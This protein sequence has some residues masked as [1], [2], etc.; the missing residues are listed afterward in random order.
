MFGRG[1][2]EGPPMSGSYVSA[3]RSPPAFLTASAATT[4]SY[5]RVLFNPLIFRSCV[6][7]A[8]PRSGFDAHQVACNRET[9]LRRALWHTA[10]NQQVEQ[11][12]CAFTFAGLPL[13]TAGGFRCRRPAVGCCVRRLHPS[14]LHLSPPPPRDATAPPMGRG[15]G[16]R[17][18]VGLLEWLRLQMVV[19]D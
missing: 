2:F 12:A 11:G 3:S 7:A 6:A 4:S 1:G 15:V 18:Q 19:V 14:R 16:P 10:R 13:Q 9:A 17:L 8:L 5:T